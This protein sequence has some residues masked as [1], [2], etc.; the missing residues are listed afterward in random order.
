MLHFV[1]P[2]MD[3]GKSVSH[4]PWKAHKP[5][6]ETK[7]FCWRYF[8]KQEG[9]ESMKTDRRNPRIDSICLL[10]EPPNS[11]HAQGL[12]YGKEILQSHFET[13]QILNTGD[14]YSL[15]CDNSGSQWRRVHKVRVAVH[16]NFQV[17]TVCFFTFLITDSI[18]KY[19]CVYFV[20]ILKVPFRFNLFLA[21]K[22][23]WLKNLVDTVINI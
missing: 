15:R 16:S 17:V 23:A 22:D 1:P 3:N 20:W 21:N 18:Y 8:P 11:H 10:K 14:N 4:R 13:E 19:I 6:K 5:V 7:E 12:H 2:F 9:F